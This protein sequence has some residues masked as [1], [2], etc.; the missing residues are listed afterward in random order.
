MASGL[1]DAVEEVGVE[2]RRQADDAVLAH[3]GTG[4]DARLGRLKGHHLDGSGSGS[5]VR[6]GVRVGV[7]V[8]VRATGSGAVGKARV[9]VRVCV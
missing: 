4:V 9:R 6:V 2:A 3:G 1:T 7:R 5:E 8:R